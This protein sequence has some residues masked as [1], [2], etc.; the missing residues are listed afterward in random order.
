VT[1]IELAT[2]TD[3]DDDQG[4]LHH[5]RFS[6]T[7]TGGWVTTLGEGTLSAVTQDMEERV[8]QPC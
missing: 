3:H 1:T 2:G 6:S 7:D 4:V 8:P 5:L